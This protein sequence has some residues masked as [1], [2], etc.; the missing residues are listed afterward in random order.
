MLAR[1]TYFYVDRIPKGA[2]ITG[3]SRSVSFQISFSPSLSQVGTLPT[4]IND[5]ILTG[6]DDFANVD[7]RVNKAGLN[8]RLDNDGAFPVNGSIVVN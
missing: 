6:H 4:I 2:G 1:N 8:T 5:A 7:V 3:A